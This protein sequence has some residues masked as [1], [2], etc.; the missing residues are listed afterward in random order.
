[1]TR[2]RLSAWLILVAL[3]C[4]A[5][6]QSAPS[7]AAR[8]PKWVL[9]GEQARQEKTETVPEVEPEPEEVEGEAGA[10]RFFFQGEYLGWWIR[11]SDFPPLATTGAVGDARPGAIG[12]PG[13]RI[14]FGSPN[15]DNEIRNGG[16]FTLTRWVGE[17]LFG[18]E[19][20]YMFLGS[21]SIGFLGFSSGDVILARPFFNTM[22]GEDASIIAFP[23]IASGTIDIAASSSMHGAEASLL[24]N[25]WCGCILRIDGLVGFRYLNLEEDLRIDEVTNLTPAAPRFA[26]TQIRVTDQFEASNNFYGGQIG[27]RAGLEFRKFDFKAI[28]KVALGGTHQVVDIRGFSNT[29]PL[30]LP[31]PPAPPPPGTPLGPG[32]LA[33]SSNSGRDTSGEFSIVPEI[34]VSTGFRLTENFRA[35]AGY[36]FLFWNRVV[37][38]GDQVDRT[39]NPNL[40]PTSATFGAAGGPARPARTGADTDF[41]AHG[42]NVGLEFRY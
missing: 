40:I 33:L 27:L 22:S 29:V 39:L 4:V 30:P 1:M 35:F 7:L 14:L 18:M 17:R 21:R 24:A 9:T 16:R 13:T 26:S 5:S 28:G 19:A 41:W 23:G 3:P 36:T 34:A 38:P 6:G 32:L 8:E 12:M 20:S 2:A 42:V 10:R 31:A 37:R 11:D 25:F 15:T